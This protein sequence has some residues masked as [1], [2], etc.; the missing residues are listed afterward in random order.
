MTMVRKQVYLEPEQ[1]REIK[2]EANIRGVTEA[3]IIRERVSAGR[4][5]RPFSRDPKL[6]EELLSALEAVMAT[7]N[8]AC[9]ERDISFDREELYDDDQP[10]TTSPAL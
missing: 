2:H 10:V 7:A 9:A 3:E 5:P 1:D 8:P 4:P 6:R